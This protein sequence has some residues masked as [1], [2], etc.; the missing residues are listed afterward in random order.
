M[1]NQSMMGFVRYDGNLRKVEKEGEVDSSIQ[2]GS[3][4]ACTLLV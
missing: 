3:G 1:V 2:A 4:Y